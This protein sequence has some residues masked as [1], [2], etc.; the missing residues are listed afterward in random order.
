MN[1]VS[2]SAGRNSDFTRSGVTFFP[3]SF[4]QQIQEIE[5]NLEGSTISLSQFIARFRR[6]WNC[7]YWQRRSGQSTE[8]IPVAKIHE[9]R[10]SGKNRFDRAKSTIPE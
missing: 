8:Y 3:V 6:H 7:K 9:T 4:I 10:S 1:S 2:I 5:T